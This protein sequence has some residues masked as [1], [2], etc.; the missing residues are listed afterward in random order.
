MLKGWQAAKETEKLSVR[1]TAS[2]RIAAEHGLAPAGATAWG[3]ELRLPRT[4]EEEAAYK[5]S[6]GVRR[7]LDVNP[8]EAPYVGKLFRRAADGE[9]VGSLA[10]WAATA[11][12]SW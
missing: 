7:I 10:R 12:S 11:S 8:V 5:I 6:K 3:Y 9:T 4:V 2:K 1:V